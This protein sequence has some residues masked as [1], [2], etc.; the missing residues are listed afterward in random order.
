MKKALVKIFGAVMS[1][2][3]MAIAAGASF[4]FRP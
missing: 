1:L 3:A 4:S 2:I